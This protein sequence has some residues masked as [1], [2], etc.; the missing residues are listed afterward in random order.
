MVRYFRDTFNR[1]QA[2]EAAETIEELPHGARIISASSY[3]TSLWTRTAQV[4]AAL[5]GGTT[6]NYFLKV[7]Q[8]SRYY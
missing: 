8:Q 4:V 2:L 1:Y 3:G 6:K 7:Y 5:P